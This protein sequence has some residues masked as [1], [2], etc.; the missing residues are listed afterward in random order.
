MS[1][2]SQKSNQRPKSTV[3]DLIAGGT[4]GLFEALCCHPLDTI[5]V[6]MQLY[7]KATTAGVKAPGLFATGYNIFA[8]E[9]FFALYK[10]L[11]AVCIGIV[12]KMAIRF[13]SYGFYRSL[14]TDEKG[15]ISGPFTFLSGVMAGVTE[16]CIVVNPMEVVK[17]RMQ[18]QHNSL[19]DPLA[20]PK[21]TNA[22]Q[23]A[24]LI[25]KEEGLKT[26]WR[27][28]ALTAGRQA[29]NQGAN[30]TTYSF[31]KSR[32]QDSQ[33]TEV[34]PTY[35][36]AVIGFISGAIGP[37]CNNPLDTIKTR[38]QKETGIS[39]ESNL[40]RGLRIG[41]NLIKESGVTAFYKGIIP[42]VIRVASGQCVVFPVYEFFKG[43][44]YEVAGYDKPEK[45]LK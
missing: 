36:T 26:L 34:L 12:P 29:I 22:P 41:K 24:V 6:R 32:L 2:A 1:S 31:L 19:R 33:N 3:I 4:A 37:F 20:K 45:K 10:G 17:I 27:G 23:A 28:V 14:F 44:L 40:S 42:R 38:M 16:A 5:K 43:F 15:N 25:V 8:Q 7:K 35:Q 39:N 30:F 18:A 9:G 21:Y 11:S 13:S